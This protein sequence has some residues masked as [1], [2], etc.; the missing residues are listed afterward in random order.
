MIAKPG[1]QLRDLAVRIASHVLPDINSAY[2]QADAGLISG[3][4]MT[5]A[6]DYERAVYNRMADIEE[7]QKL[8]GA[9]L[10]RKAAYPHADTLA[11]VSEEKP[12][13]L[14]LQDVDQCHAEYFQQL[15]TLHAW[16]EQNSDELNQ[17]IWL[18]LRR[19]SERNKFD[20]AGP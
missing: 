19:H 4:L 7:M 3:L 14:H 1:T 13:S 20:V 12:Q 5:L 18:L 2:G 17:Q 11:A 16:A 6:Q 8:F 9:V 10:E 15:I